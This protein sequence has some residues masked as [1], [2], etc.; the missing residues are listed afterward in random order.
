MAAPTVCGQRRV[1]LVGQFAVAGQAQRPADG[2][3]EARR[4]PPMSQPSRG[5][6]P[7][8]MIP[9]MAGAIV[10]PTT[11]G[12]VACVDGSALQRGRVRQH[13]DDAGDPQRVGRRVREQG[14]RP[15]AGCCRGSGHRAASARRPR[16]RRTTSR[17]WHPALLR[18]SA[19]LSLPHGIASTARASDAI[20][21][22]HCSPSDTCDRAILGCRAADQDEPEHHD[23]QAD[24]VRPRQ[25][26]PQHDRA[27]HG[28]HRRASWR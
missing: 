26:H 28:R 4:R 22:P 13:C 25:P 8:R 16:S 14:R 3:G 17:R 18:S 1:V 23:D 6:S 20:S 7:S 10:S 2:E 24:L 12:A 19:P 15:R 27:Q 5:R 9:T 21:T 11:S